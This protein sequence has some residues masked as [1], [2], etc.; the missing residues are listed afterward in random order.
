MPNCYVGKL[1]LVLFPIIFFTF[2]IFFLFQLPSKTFAANRYVKPGGTDSGV[3]LTSG[4]ACLTIQYTIGQ[5]STG[6]TINIANGTYTEDVTINKA[7]TLI[8]NVGTGIGPGAS[9]PTIQPASCASS[10][11][12]VTVASATIEG[13]IVNGNSCGSPQTGIDIAAGIGST[14]VTHN[15]LLDNGNGVFLETGS[16][17]SNTIQYNNIHANTIYG[18]IVNNTASSGSPTL[19]DHNTI[20]ADGQGGIIIDGTGVTITNNTITNHTTGQGAGID[21]N[22][23][24]NITIHYNAISGNGPGTDKPHDGGGIYHDNLDNV[25]AIDNYWGSSTGPTNSGNPSG[26]GDVVS[27]YVLFTPFY[28]DAGLTTLN[29]DSTNTSTSTSSLSA[30]SAPTCGQTAPTTKPYLYKITTKGT[31]VTLYF[32]PVTGATAYQIYYGFRAGD[33]RFGT[34]FSGT[35]PVT[36]KYLNPH[37]QFYFAVSGE[38]VCAGGP[39]SNWLGVVSGKSIAL[40]ANNNGAQHKSATVSSQSISPT[41]LSI[42]IPENSTP[43]K[44]LFS[45]IWNFFLHIFK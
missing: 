33:K 8:G 37:T 6:D 31:S 15:E 38:N 27:D 23:A 22:T 19:I 34:T 13:I 28:T 39:L 42:P 1:K 9:A 7:I 10:A 5:S 20:T 16:S 3:C 36:I 45:N 41:P 43:P 18:I 35:D 30:A 25:D 12:S 14:T 4:T 21:A 40:V 17:N 11:I 26:T 24:T 2:L 29:T 44:S 32:T